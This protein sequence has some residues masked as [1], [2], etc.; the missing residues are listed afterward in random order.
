MLDALEQVINKIDSLK[1]DTSNKSK[2]LDNLS[3]ELDKLKIIVT[4]VK[5][6]I[7]SNTSVFLSSL[8][9]MIKCSFSVAPGTYLSVRAT[10]LVGNMPSSNISDSKFMI[11]IVPFG[12]CL[13][14]TNPFFKPPFIVPPLPCIPT[15]SPFIP[16]QPTVLLENM[17]V[18]TEKSKAMCTF[19]PGGVVSF[20]TPGQFNAQTK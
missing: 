11:N 4:P 8:S 9:G 5:L 7:S 18:T 10:T 13:N 2:D 16:T 12:G 17:P 19:A 3:N 1:K 14:V 20:I 15:L 6:D